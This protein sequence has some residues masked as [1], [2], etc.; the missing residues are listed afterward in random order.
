MNEN[1]NRSVKTLKVRKV[2]PPPQK[3]PFDKKLLLPVFAGITLVLFIVLFIIIGTLSSK[4][5]DLNDRLSESEEY[6]N[7]VNTRVYK[8]AQPGD[9]IYL[10]DPTYGDTWLPVLEDVPVNTRD[11]SN[12]SLNEDNRYTYYVNGEKASFTGIDVSYFQEDID[13]QKVAAD[14]IDFVI[15][16]AGYRGY[17]TGKI[18]ED[19]KFEEYAKGASE[20]GLDIGVYFYSQA[21][22]EEEAK[23]EAQFVCELLEPYEIAYP[24]AFDWEVTGEEAARTN[25]ISPETLTK[26]ALAFC[27]EIAAAGYRPMLYGNLRMAL[28]KFD[29][30]SLHQYDFWFAQYKDGHHPP[31]YP[32]EL[33]IWQYASDGKVDGISGDVDMNISF[34]DYRSEYDALQKIMGTQDKTEE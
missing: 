26:C 21:L 34:V 33:S 5:T 27:N 31:E 20:A 30:R 24:V 1:E 22:T 17:E 3:P 28:L 25:D 2:Q 23:A 11:Y 13:W 18:N 14:G 10:S 29:L 19:S 15:L 16:R 9:V 32:Y 7:A 12:L 4:I 6:I 8:Y